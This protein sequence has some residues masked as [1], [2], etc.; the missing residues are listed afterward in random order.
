MEITAIEAI[1]IRVPLKSLEKGGIAPYVTNHQELETVDRVLVRVETDEGFDG[2]GEVRTF[3]SP[4]ATVSVI[5]DGV[6]PLVIGQSPFEVESLRRQLFIEYTNVDMFFAPIEIACWD[7]R[8]KALDESIATLL[9]G[10]TAR[11]HSNRKWRTEV[12]ASNDDRVEVAYCLGILPPA[13]SAA[14]AETVLDEGYNV[15]KTKAGR[16]WK[17]DIERIVA[18]HRATDG[19]LEFRL[20]P[21]QGWTLD[22]AVRVAAGLEREGIELQYMEQP[23][24]VNSHENLAMLRKRTQQPI[25]PNEDTYIPQNF[26]QL[27][28]ADAADVAVVDMT[29][30]GG[31]SGVRN[32][33][34]I[35]EEA[36]VP[37]AH[38]CAFDLGVRTAAVL[39]A[40]HGIPGFE[41]PPDSAYDGW[42]GDVI[43]S[44][45]EV[46][47]GALSVPSGPGLGVTIDHDRLE[48]YRV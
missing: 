47:N 17:Q 15:L 33:A 28:R 41:L 6:G 39:H 35:A 32:L 2:W 19:E 3:L 22:Q 46:K 26:G 14:K 44:P 48:Q 13:E 10:K 23:I 21:N 1:P 31:I 25:A 38:H 40:V 18:M 42:A 8:G 36:G 45:F 9:G 20:D 30:V 24:R 16:D 37:L 29:P 43:E 7:I 27:I 5:E 34:A 12:E 11:G 4:E